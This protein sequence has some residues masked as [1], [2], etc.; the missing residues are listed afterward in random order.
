MYIDKLRTGFLVWDNKVKAYRARN[1]DTPFPDW[2]EGSKA[3]LAAIDNVLSR[4][5]I[6]KELI[7]LWSQE[8]DHRAGS[9]L[10]LEVRKDNV[11]FM[12]TLGAYSVSL[13]GTFH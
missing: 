4:P 6:F 2:E 13:S 12:K 11:T 9:A 10:D 7:Q 8:T 5:G 3:A 1:E